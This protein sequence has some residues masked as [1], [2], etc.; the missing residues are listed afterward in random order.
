[1][2]K[3]A[4][5]KAFTLN[6]IVPFGKENIHEAIASIKIKMQNKKQRNLSV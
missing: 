2:S 6:I 5:K 1:M 3:N 4:S